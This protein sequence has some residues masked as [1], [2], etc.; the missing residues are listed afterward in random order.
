M[1]AQVASA[2][3]HAHK[4][5]VLHRDIKPSNIMLVDNIDGADQVKVMDF[6]IAKVL[7]DTEHGAQNLTKTGDALGSPLY[8]SPE[9]C[10]GRSHE[11]TNLSDVYSLGCVMYEALTGTAPF[12]GNNVL[13]T[14]QMHISDAPL[15]L[16][17]ATL[18]ETFD[19]ILE[20]VVMKTLEKDPANRYQSMGQLEQDLLNV[21]NPNTRDLVS[22]RAAE[23]AAAP[24][25]KSGLL[26]NGLIALV[27]VAV[28]VCA[29]VA[30]YTVQHQA[31][32]PKPADVPD[33]S[34]E[35]MPL[36]AK[37]NSSA[38]TEKEM[39]ASMVQGNRKSLDLSR[40]GLIPLNDS[41]F[42]PLKNATNCEEMNLSKTGISDKGL[43]YISKLRLNALY[44]TNTAVKDLHAIKNMKSLGGLGVGGTSL[45]EEG[46]K[47]IL[48]L[49]LGWIDLSSTGISD[50]DLLKLT[51]IKTLRNLSVQDCT[52]LTTAGINRFKQKAPLVNVILPSGEGESYSRV[53]GQAKRQFAEKKFVEAENLAKQ[54]IDIE[55]AGSKKNPE[56]VAD[57]LSFR[58]D[59]FLQQKHY[60]E[61]EKLKLQAIRTVE[62][63]NVRHES[64]PEYEVQLAG[65]Q[66]LSG[67]IKEAIETRLKAD[68]FLQ[69]QEPPEEDELK[70][71]R[72][73]FLDNSM[74]IA[75]DYI[76][77]KKIDK[78]MTAFKRTLALCD[79]YNESD[80]QVAAIA[81]QWYAGNLL[82]LGKAQEAIPHF[83]KAIEIYK[84]DPMFNF[85]L[86]DANLQLLNCYVSTKHYSEAEDLC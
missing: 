1:F 23:A 51:K 85:V 41:D 56:F 7:S 57:A 28:V 71:W 72:K 2:L 8:M 47:V 3:A 64:I 70:K 40:G 35:F 36:Q 68:Q 13:E 79:K 67:R 82:N 20:R 26:N 21:D 45:N 53:M 6:G 16:K 37:D 11:V 33:N 66:E 29:G 74:H 60:V 52:R 76:L 61:A 9:Q 49:P 10:L 46:L 69:Y 42:E 43:E 39:V 55:E 62:S 58:S 77:I 59:C 4:R 81:N 44:L 24:S 84:T 5:G 25:K 32:K 18:G 86:P 30:F 14:M 73:R 31:A 19:P 54:A 80:S 34:Y 12:E 38:V 48:G 78:G 17:E 75:E 65:I 22:V 83:Q 15:P 63:L 50:S 27:S